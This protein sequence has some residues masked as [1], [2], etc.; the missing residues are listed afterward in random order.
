MIADP[1]NT[2]VNQLYLDY[3]GWPDTVVRAGRQSIKLDN[4]R[5]IGNV[6]FRQVMQVFN[7]V[8]V[9]N[10]SLPNTRLYAGYLEIGRAHV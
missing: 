3:A 1:D 8:T 4:V 2:D 6:E 5:F 7:G 9:E 10:N